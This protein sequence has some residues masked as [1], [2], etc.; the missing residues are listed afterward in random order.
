[1]VRSERVVFS[2]VSR[3]LKH[4]FELGKVVSERDPHEVVSLDVSYHKECIKVDNFEQAFFQTVNLS[5]FLEG[6]VTDNL[7]EDI[8]PSF[9]VE[10]FDC[11]P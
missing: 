10:V 5:K 6:N 4:L 3:I 11:L 2:K 7:N 8:I 9:F 1:M